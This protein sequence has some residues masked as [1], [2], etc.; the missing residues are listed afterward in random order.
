[1]SEVEHASRGV[2]AIVTRQSKLLVIER[3]QLVRAPGMVCFPGGAIEH[4]ESESDAVIRELLEELSLPARAVRELWTSV[5]PWN[6]SLSWWLADVQP[7]AVPQPDPAEVASYNWLSVAEIRRLSN[8]LASNLEFLAAWE[9]GEFAI[10]G[11]S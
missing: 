7:A 11:L 9:R 3:S 8:L 4:G 10:D 5:T 2:V 6:V 1:M